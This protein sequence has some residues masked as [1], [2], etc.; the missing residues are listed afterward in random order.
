MDITARKNL[1]IVQEF[2]SCFGVGDIERA[3]SLLSDDVYWESPVSAHPPRELVWARP[4]HGRQGVLDFIH[5]MWRTV[6]PYV[7][8]TRSVSADGD[9]VIV[10]GRNQCIVRATGKMYDHEWVLIFTLKDG[11][12]TSHRQYYDTAAILEAFRSSPD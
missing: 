2:I 1:Q 3:L 10:E 12:I 5:D 4:R 9:R 7:M 8:D 11:K 6:Q